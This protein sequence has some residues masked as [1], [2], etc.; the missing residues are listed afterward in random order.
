MTHSTWLYVLVLLACCGVALLPLRPEFAPVDTVTVSAFPGWPTQ[1]EGQPLTPRPLTEREAR[2][3]RGFPGRIGRFTDGKREVIVRWVARATRQLHPA[4]D[5]FRG[6]GYTIAPLPLH[7]DAQGHLWSQF[8]ATRGP[9]AYRIR[10]YI[11]DGT[12]SWPDVSAW[13]W[14]AVLNPLRGTNTQGPWWSFTVAE[15]AMPR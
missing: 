4:T 3:A 5:C 10:E 1:F 2:F 6:L 13:Y 14:Q 8:T 9:T 11:V 12:A 15:H 7:T